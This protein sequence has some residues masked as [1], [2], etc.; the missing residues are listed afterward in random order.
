MSEDLCKNYYSHLYFTVVTFLTKIQNWCYITKTNL[1]NHNCQKSWM[2]KTTTVQKIWMGKTTTI[3]VFDHMTKNL[4]GKNHYHP[5]FWSHDQ[6]NL[7]SS[8]ISI[9]LFLLVRFWILARNG[10]SAKEFSLPPKIIFWWFKIV[11]NAQ[12]FEFSAG[13][14]LL[15][16]V[17]ESSSFYKGPRTCKVWKS[18]DPSGPW[19]FKLYLS[20]DLCKNY[21]SH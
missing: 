21:Y 2:V 19:T 18:A 3:Q 13:M 9:P 5:S 1:S 8:R 11:E 10:N 6:K 7:D 14:L 15:Q 16:K 12:D 4:D 17:N 20:L